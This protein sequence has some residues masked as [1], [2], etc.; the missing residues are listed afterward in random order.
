MSL[1]AFSKKLNNSSQE[2]SSDC[3]PLFHPQYS[4]SSTGTSNYSTSPLFTAD[5]VASFS[6]KIRGHISSPLSDIVHDY[7]SS[8]GT[9]YGHH[10]ATNFMSKISSMSD[11]MDPNSLRTTFE[12]F[13]AYLNMN[14]L[15]NNSA[16][17]QGVQ[18]QDFTRLL[19]VP[20]ASLLASCSLVHFIWL[21]ITY[22]CFLS[23]LLS[24]LFAWMLFKQRIPFA[25]V[26]V[27]HN[28]NYSLKSRACAFA[29]L[30]YLLAYFLLLTGCIWSLL[31]RARRCIDYFSTFIRH[32]R[33]VRFL[34]FYRRRLFGSNN[35]IIEEGNFIL[36]NIPPMSRE[37]TTRTSLSTK[38]GL[39]LRGRC[40]IPSI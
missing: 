5:N 28:W 16:N 30:Y 2:H 39:K 9:S 11:F 22:L 35:L 12:P 27:K 7:V 32:S 20:P 24:F 38:I 25:L 29:G 34:R 6:Q 8:V 23:A 26:K 10:G 31:S 33:I 13:N 4:V 17:L 18:E 15:Q 14:A 21:C 3:V 36:E 1:K 37:A 19:M 40:R